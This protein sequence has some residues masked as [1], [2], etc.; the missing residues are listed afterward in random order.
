MSNNIPYVPDISKILSQ[1][2]PRL[3][4]PTVPYWSY[5]KESWSNVPKSV[6]DKQKLANYRTLNNY[7]YTYT[8]Y[9]DWIEK[10]SQTPAATTRA[11]GGLM[12]GEV[13][14]LINANSNFPD[15]RSQTAYNSNLFKNYFNYVLDKNPSMFQVYGNKY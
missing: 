12:G 2:N 3:P 5:D 14:R 10:Q 6:T 4:N 1:Q 7:N 11:H 13:D 15:L 8:G 9:W